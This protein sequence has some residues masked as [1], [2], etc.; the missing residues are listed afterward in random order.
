VISLNIFLFD[1]QTVTS[2][3]LFFVNED[4]FPLSRE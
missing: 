1:S 4:G 2:V 3:L